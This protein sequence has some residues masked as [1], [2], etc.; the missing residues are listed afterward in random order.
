[1][2]SLFSRGCH[3]P[4]GNKHLAKPGGSLGCRQ[5]PWVEGPQ[6]PA[7][8]RGYPQP[9]GTG[10]G[11]GLHSSRG[12]EPRTVPAKDHPP[13]VGWSSGLLNHKFQPWPETPHPVMVKGRDAPGGSFS[14][15][16]TF[17]SFGLKSQT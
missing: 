1:M 8:D 10:V 9:W 12:L 16:C 11:M 15:E 13:A 7:A 5:F 14:S 6:P 4:A 17:S 3:I 2:T